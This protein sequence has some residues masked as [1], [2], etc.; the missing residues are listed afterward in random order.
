MQIVTQFVDTPRKLT[1]FIIAN[2]LNKSLV[3]PENAD[4]HTLYG[5]TKKTGTTK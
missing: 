5:Y 1:C 3:Y 4:S 2:I